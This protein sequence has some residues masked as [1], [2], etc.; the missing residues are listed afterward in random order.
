[1]SYITRYEPAALVNEVNRIMEN[2]FRPLA[3]GDTSNIETSQ[4]IPGVDIKE[5]KNQN[6]AIVGRKGTAPSEKEIIK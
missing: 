2:A 4:W 1:M 5:E 6:I 3:S